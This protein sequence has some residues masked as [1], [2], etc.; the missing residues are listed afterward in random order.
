MVV[1]SSVVS[2]LLERLLSV[3]VGHLAMLAKFLRLIVHFCISRDSVVNLR[4]YSRYVR[5]TEVNIEL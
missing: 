1:V 2:L 5:G 4:W 3:T